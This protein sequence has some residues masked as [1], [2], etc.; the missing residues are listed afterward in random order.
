MRSTHLTRNRKAIVVRRRRPSQPKAGRAHSMNRSSTLI[1]SIAEVHTSAGSVAEAPEREN[2]P[3]LSNVEL[4]F[5][6][7]F[8]PMGFAVEIKTNDKAVLAAAN[9]SWGGLNER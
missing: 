6:A 2:D 1:G 7:I 9:E 4:P 5:R 8:Y 3:L